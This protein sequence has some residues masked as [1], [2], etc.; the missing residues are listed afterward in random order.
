ML[1]K[2]LAMMKTRFGLAPDQNIMTPEE[3]A[4]CLQEIKANMEANAAR[5]RKESSGSGDDV[6]STSPS[7]YPVTLHVS[8]GGG[9][10]P[11]TAP[12]STS[13]IDE[14]DKK[15]GEDSDESNGPKVEEGSSSTGGEMGGA[16]YG[17]SAYGPFNPSPSW[18]PIG[19]A[20]MNAFSGGGGS[21][22][23]PGHAFSPALGGG[24]AGSTKLPPISN[25]FQEKGGAGGG[26][27]R[28]VGSVGGLGAY[29][30]PPYDYFSQ[31]S[32]Q[33]LY[34][35]GSEGGGLAGGA[36]PAD[37][38]T[39][40]NKRQEEASSARGA[41]SVGLTSNGAGRGAGGG[42]GGGPTKAENLGHTMIPSPGAGG[43]NGVSGGML[44][45][46]M[47]AMTS[48]LV[49]SNHNH[50]NGGRSPGVG[51]QDSQMIVRGLTLP[52]RLNTPGGSSE[53]GAGAGV[54]HGLAA[55]A[56]ALAAGTQGIKGPENEHLKRENDALKMTLR[57]LT[58]QMEHM[59]DQ[60][61]KD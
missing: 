42:M 49:H 14:M 60:V 38:S 55:E 53:G 7:V 6:S 58:A 35:A 16:G 19:A 50:N 21:G 18:G 12:T 40:R 48:P 45:D 3:R 27:G 9:S 61:Y 4:Q 2:E 39:N 22:G 20:G 29:A 59:K 51:G 15:C 25:A 33:M 24:V 10:G 32:S 31:Y 8:T 37:L 52:T 1:R 46:D 17:P 26:F 5:R 28:F 47:V 23:A 34:G 44:L 30:R 57:T 43:A 13:S 36:A 56:S 11:G 41:S 54:T